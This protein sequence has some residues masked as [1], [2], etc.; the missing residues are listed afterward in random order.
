MHEIGT[1]ALS[2]HIIFST[3]SENR[4]NV[5]FRFLIFL[6]DYFLRP[7]MLVVLFLMCQQA[8]SEIPHDELPS[9]VRQFFS[10]DL[11]KKGQSIHVEHALLRFCINVEGTI[12][13]D[14][15]ANQCAA[16]LSRNL[17]QQFVQ[18]VH[19]RSHLDTKIKC[20]NSKVPEQCADTTKPYVNSGLPKNGDVTQ[21]RDD[22]ALKPSQPHV[23]RNFKGKSNLMSA[24]AVFGYQVLQ[25]PHFAELCWVTSKL[26]EGPVADVRGPWKVWPFNSCIVRPYSA[27]Q[28]INVS[29]APTNENGNSK[30]EEKFGLVRGLVAVGLSAYRGTYESAKTVSF[31][32]REVLELLVEQINLKIQAGRERHDYVRVLSQVSY[33]EDL[34]NSWA[35]SLQRYGFPFIYDINYTRE[36]LHMLGTC[37]NTS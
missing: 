26:K 21:P 13:C 19:G 22:P 17:V 9:R 5:L 32:I 4:V 20:I 28:S 25:Y 34:V 1:A 8:T 3:D 7:K 36:N 15:T 11:L 31:E 33:L 6:T 14:T 16:K 23:K 10:N 37:I 18:L 30:E 24:I 27:E 2:R 35:Y 29:G 12:N